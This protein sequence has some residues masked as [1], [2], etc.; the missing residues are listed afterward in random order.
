MNGKYFRCLPFLFMLGFI[1]Q[2]L[3]E[4]RWRLFPRRVSQEEIRFLNS[5][6]PYFSRLKAQFRKEFIGKLEMILS[7]KRF[8]GRDGLE[9][10]TWQMEILIGATLTMVTFGWKRLKLAHFHTILIYPN[11]YFSTINRTYHKGEVNPKHGLIIISWRSFVEGLADFEDG[12]NLGIHEVAHALKLANFIHSDG[13]RE[14][15]PQAWEEYKKWV[16]AEI[17]KIQLGNPTI[18]RDRGGVDEHEF[19]AVVVETFFE[20]SE[21]FKAYNPKFYQTMVYL[22]KQD[23]LVLLS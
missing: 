6:F 16:P 19:F 8:I 9:E 20:K 23:P 3:N 10:V 12:V 1:A 21:E 18:F 15:N 22:L 5:H 17:Q 11:P 14:F 13:E 4:A 7:T 2:Y